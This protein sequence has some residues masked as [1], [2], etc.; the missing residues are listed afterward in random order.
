MKLP[1]KLLMVTAL[2]GLI[3]CEKQGSNPEVETYINQFLALRDAQELD[4]VYD[5]KS[6]EA[7]AKAYYDWWYSSYMLNDKMNIDP[8]KDTDYRWH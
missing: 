2:F 3:G 8:L 7:A 1:F 5:T 6:Q 4:L